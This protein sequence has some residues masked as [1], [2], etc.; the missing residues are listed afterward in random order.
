MR[1]KPNQEINFN[2][3][4]SISFD[5]FT[6]PYVQYAFARASGILRLGSGQVLRLGLGQVLRQAQ[7]KSFQGVDFSVLKDEKESILLRYLIQ[8]P[9]KI[10]LAV[11]GF[12]PAIISEHIF[13]IAKAFNNF[14]TFCPVLAMGKRRIEKSS[15][16]FGQGDRHCFEK[17]FEFIR[18]RRIRGY[19]V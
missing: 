6:G 10:K 16:D 1:V 2:P 15:I 14:Y 7:D 19:V 18:D 5:G 4:E 9:E 13:E 3:E 11:D 8:F 17:R 12:N